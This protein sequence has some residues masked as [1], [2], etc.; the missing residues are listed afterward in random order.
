MLL[1]EQVLGNGRASRSRSKLQRQSFPDPARRTGGLP[2]LLLPGASARPGRPAAGSQLQPRCSQLHR[3]PGR[4]LPRQVQLG[5][6]AAEVYTD[7]A[8][9]GGK[10]SLTC[11]EIFRSGMALQENI[12]SVCFH[13]ASLDPENLQRS[14][15]GSCQ[16]IDLT[17]WSVTQGILRESEFKSVFPGS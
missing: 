8:G 16:D 6:L 17:I 7:P 3:P 9:S 5:S 15:S 2:H 4:S 14:L 13:T 11:L 10:V 12:Y 1:C